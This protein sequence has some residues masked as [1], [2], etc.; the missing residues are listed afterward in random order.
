[1]ER[2]LSGGWFKE[3]PR[4]SRPFGAGKA[5]AILKDFWDWADWT[6]FAQILFLTLSSKQATTD[7]FAGY[8]EKV[9]ISNRSQEIIDNLEI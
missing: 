4:G 9:F 6:Q 8:L 2:I 7:Q 1:M 5:E 3:R